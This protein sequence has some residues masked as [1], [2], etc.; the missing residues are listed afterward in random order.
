MAHEAA[1]KA[2]VA[3][4]MEFFYELRLPTEDSIAA[5]CD[6]A[7][8][9]YEKHD[10]P[11]IAALRELANEW[12]RSVTGHYMGP[13]ETEEA[14]L[15]CVEELRAVLDKLKPIKQTARATT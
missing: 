4:G 6:V 13:R 10:A 5:A 1:V 14:T 8:H 15:R 3:V 9:A 11:D 12:E 2:G 7:V